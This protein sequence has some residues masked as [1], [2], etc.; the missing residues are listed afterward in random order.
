MGPGFYIHPKS[1]TASLGETVVFSCA[2]HGAYHSN[3]TWLKDG[4]SL[5]NNSAKMIQ[6]NRQQ[7]SELH[8]ISVSE[9]DIGKYSCLAAIGSLQVLS[10]DAE[11]SLKG[12][13]IVKQ[14]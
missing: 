4:T 13:K 9:T 12:K 6:G 11:L 2:V 7:S 5:T 3:I 10:R 1:I 14:G 8:I